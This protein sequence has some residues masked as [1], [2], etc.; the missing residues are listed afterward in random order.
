MVSD[1]QVSAETVIY[2]A[3]VWNGEIGLG[4]SLFDF[5]E[6]TEYVERLKIMK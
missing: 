5:L 2:G 4:F 3:F 6:Q 1:S